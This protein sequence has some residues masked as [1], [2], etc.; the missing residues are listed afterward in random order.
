MSSVFGAVLVLLLAL[1]LIGVEPVA[2]WSWWLV[3]LPVWIAS[4]LWL[5]AVVLAVIV[6]S[7]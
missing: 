1:K 2:S 5:V 4:A 6:E 3:L 7:K